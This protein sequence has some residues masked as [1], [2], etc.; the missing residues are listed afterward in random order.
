M[1][2]GYSGTPLPRKLGLKDGQRVAFIGLPPELAWLASAAAFSEVAVEPGIDGFGPMRP[3]DVIHLFTTRRRL[4][5]DGL[6]GLMNSITPDGMIWVSWPK[7]ASKVAT[8]VTEDVVRELALPIGLVD[9]KVCAIDEVWSG[10]KLMVRR[11]L[12]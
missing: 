12:R 4:L 6:Q 8:D 11:E 7:R 1:A 10:L 2:A 5:E 3:L 9:V